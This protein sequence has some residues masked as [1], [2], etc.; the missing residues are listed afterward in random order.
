M[1]DQIIGKIYKIIGLIL[2]I[3]ILALIFWLRSDRASFPTTQPES[4]FQLAPL[5]P[6]FSNG[7]TPENSTSSTAILPPPSQFSY[8][9][10]D[11]ASLNT[12]NTLSIEIKCQAAYYT[13]LVFSSKDDYRENPAAA[14]FNQATPCRLGE[15]IK[16]S[17]DLKELN[18]TAGR[19]YYIRADQGQAGSWY[20]AR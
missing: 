15:E 16:R 11:L 20:N 10:Y 14:R 5:S 9:N 8:F 6:G 12:K 4:G 17:L 3:L 1:R 2:M 13:I 7:S 19:Y 18:L